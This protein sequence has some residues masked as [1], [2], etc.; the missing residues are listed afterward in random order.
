MTELPLIGNLDEAITE[1]KNRIER[2][3]KSPRP[4]A[5][6]YML[7]LTLLTPGYLA[8]HI[9]DNFACKFDSSITNVPG[10]KTK[11]VF[12]G[13]TVH[14]FVPFSPVFGTS[15]HAFIIFS[16]GDEVRINSFWDSGKGIDGNMVQAEIEKNFDK[17]I[18][19]YA[20]KEE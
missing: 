17:A 13:A 19:M 14:R 10:P 11:L 5:Y 15:G 16:Y 6:F 18:E 9:I 3:K 1:M 7:V 8:F 2:L 12:A 20:D 4:Y